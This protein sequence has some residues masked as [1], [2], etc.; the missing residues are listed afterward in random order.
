MLDNL[1]D[2]KTGFKHD[3]EQISYEYTRKVVGEQITVVFYEMTTFY[4]EAFDEDNLRIAAS[5]KTASTVVSKSSSAYLSQPVK[6]RFG[7]EIFEENIFEGYTLIPIIEKLA[8]CFS[9]A[10]PIVVM[11]TG[12]LTKNNLKELESKGYNCYLE[13]EGEVSIRI[14]YDNFNAD[15]SWNGI[16]AYVI[17]TSLPE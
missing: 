4:I 8:A 14:N 7:H 10:Q 15:V 17:N 13:M 3:V 12:L 1:V 2:G 9:F 5:Q 16:K 6:I 11:D